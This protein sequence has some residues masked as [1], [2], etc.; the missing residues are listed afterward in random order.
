MSGHL[1]PAK[2]WRQAFKRIE[3][4]YNQNHPDTPIKIHP[5]KFRHTTATTLLRKR[6]SVTSTQRM[7]RHALIQM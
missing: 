7:L 6:L 5:H 4:W 1:S 3:D 2:E